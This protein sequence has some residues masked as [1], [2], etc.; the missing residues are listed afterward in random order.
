MTNV[1]PKIEPSQPSQATKTDVLLT[2]GE[3][4]HMLNAA[5][6]ELTAGQTIRVMTTATYPTWYVLA[7]SHGRALHGSE[8]LA[9]LADVMAAD[10]ALAA[11][12]AEDL[13]RGNVTADSIGRAHT[14]YARIEDSRSRAAAGSSR[15]ISARSSGNVKRW[16]TRPGQ[17]RAPYKY[18]LYES[19]AVTAANVSAWH[20]SEASA[21]NGPIW[22]N[23]GSESP[24]I[25]SP[26][27]IAEDA[28]IAAAVKAKG[29]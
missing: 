24:Y 18:G 26:K 8:S 20:H 22:A 1:Q 21:A 19:F 3:H 16:K 6:I 15:V 12:A 25:V 29:E 7:D 17:F 10:R 2:S 23:P 9:G 5:G 28:T 13:A 14:I 11:L 4:S 27:M